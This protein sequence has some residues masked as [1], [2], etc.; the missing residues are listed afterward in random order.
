MKRILTITALLLAS[1]ISVYAT[2]LAKIC[3]K[4]E[5]VTTITITKQ[6]MGLLPKMS[7]S[8]V[9]LGPLASK[10]DQVEIINA[11]GDVQLANVKKCVRKYLRDNP[12]FSETLS[13][14]D[15]NEKIN[16]YMQTSESELNE[17]L[18]VIEDPDE[19]TLVLLQGTLTP[20]DV[21]RYTKFGL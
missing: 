12:G 4:I 13:V 7:E 3:S 14:T 19:M 8:H 2:G 18:V 5:G 20:A 10:L 1:V 17:Y 9:S 11:E 21:S 16:L 6:M 15:A